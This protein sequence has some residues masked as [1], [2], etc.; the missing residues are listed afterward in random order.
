MSQVGASTGVVA[1]AVWQATAALSLR[2]SAKFGTMGM[3]LEL[4]GTQQI[5]EFSSAGC[6]VMAGMQVQRPFLNDLNL[7][8][9]SHGLLLARESTRGESASVWES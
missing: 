8:R 7:T 9:R 4:G 2:A 6:A 5:T 1:K 3:E